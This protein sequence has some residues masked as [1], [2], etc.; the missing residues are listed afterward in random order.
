MQELKD[1]IL[2]DGEVIGSNILKVDSFLN[3]QLDPA[4]IMRMGEELARRFTDAGITRVLTVEASGIVVA[5]AVGL[6]LG[7]PVVF[8]KKKKASTQNDVYRSQIYSF[9]R[10]ESVD[11]TVTKR[12]LRSDDTVLIIDD[13]LAH[14]EA[15]KGLVDIVK[16]SGARL[17][18][19][20]IVIE[21]RFQRGAERLRAEG[22]R[23]EALAA[24]EAMEPGNI[25]FA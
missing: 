13:F 17:A 3:H 23:I 8:A 6:T 1:R 24:I 18:G 4:F 15:L 19:A 2:V 7:V 5:S 20:G 25:R 10:Q 9:T 16:Q 14:G 21:K 11:I 22:M 12:Y